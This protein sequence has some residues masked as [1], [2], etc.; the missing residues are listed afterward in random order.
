MTGKIPVW[1]EIPAE[2]MGKLPEKFR[3]WR[4]ISLTSSS[5]FSIAASVNGHDL[6][7]AFVVFKSSVF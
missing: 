2:G 5:V 4:K 3:V 1:W 6:S 7:I